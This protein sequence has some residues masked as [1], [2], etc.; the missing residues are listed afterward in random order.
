MVTSGL[1]V[2]GF[3]NDTQ[4]TVTGIEPENFELINGLQNI[5][6]GKSLEVNDEN[7][8]VLGKALSDS[9]KASIGDLVVISTASGKS[10]NFMVVGVFES[11]S[12]AMNTRL[13][14]QLDS[15]QELADQNGKVSTVGV[16]CTTP[17]VADYV[18]SMI[19]NRIPA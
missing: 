14:I 12:S 4:C 8:V 17:D 10:Q 18:A 11:P 2:N 15:S 5:I 13:Y 7:G 3:V 1:S 19:P 9:L 6:S 16:K